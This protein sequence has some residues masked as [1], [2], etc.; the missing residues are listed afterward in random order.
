M[1]KLS[2]LY[3]IDSDVEIEDI[4]INSKECHKGSLFVCT[5]GVNSDR[6]DFID[7]AIAHGASALVVSRDVEASVPWVKVED[8]NVELPKLCDKFYDYPGKTLKMIG[9]TGTDGKTTTS[10]LVQ[11]FLGKD[12]C[13]LTG[14]NGLSLGDYTE[15]TPNTTADAPYLY[16]YFH[17]FVEKGAKYACMEASSEAFF[18]GR[19][20]EMMWDVTGYTNIT[21][22]HLNIH[23][24]IENYAECKIQ[25]FRQTKKDG[26]CV[27]NHDDKFFEMA[28]E[29]CNGHVLT[30]GKGDDND[31]VIKDY[32]LYPDHTDITFILHG[33]E[34]KINSPLLAEFNI[35][36]LACAIL[37]VTCLGV[38]IDEIKERLVGFHVPG[39]MEVLHENIPFHVIVDYAH[40]P[41]GI[42]NLLDF[43]NTLDINRSIV[44]I[45][46]AGTRDAD[47]RPIMGQVVCENASYGIFTY[48][49]P[50][51]E[52]PMEIC[53]QLVSEVSKTRDNFEIVVDRHDAIEKA[54]MMAEDNDIVLVL[55]KGVED[56][57]II[58]KEE[59][60][61]N[62]LEEV[63]KAIKK[64]ENK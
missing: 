12:I 56:Y 58:G 6:H 32:K 27:L 54:I 39:R 44:V 37:M 21:R 15:D 48:E 61:F 42:K 13:G 3:D 46:S 45:G 18:R 2:E 7:D 36:N 33:E 5:K 22:D 60:P 49:D 47:K 19:L 23:K 62:D 30:Y 34:V 51:T 17:T 11:T 57:E 24:T 25:L 26:Y 50:R 1:K 53:K 20:T 52:D 38:T 10:T 35:Y 8:T 14:T 41:N 28:K 9:V 40:T 63:L 31:L 64:R 55:G 43:V 59:I 4:S 29:A 16:R